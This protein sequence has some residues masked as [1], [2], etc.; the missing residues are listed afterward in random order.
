[1]KEC[2]GSAGIEDKNLQFNKKDSPIS[3]RFIDLPDRMEELRSSLKASHGNAAIIIH[4]FFFKKDDIYNF[5]NK[6][7]Y[8]DQEYEK[9]KCRLKNS[10]NKYTKLGL[11]IIVFEEKHEVSKLQQNFENIKINNGDIYLVPTFPSD[12]QPVG[13]GLSPLL[14]EFKKIGLTRTIIAG[15]YL[16]I[17]NSKNMYHEPIHDC[18]EHI[19]R[20]FKSYILAGCVGDALKK[21]LKVGIN[22]TPAFATFPYREIF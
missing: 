6:L 8:S 18:E 19:P 7:C 1:M 2:L 13:I 16:W 15:S 9:Y 22:A 11:P 21:C 14:R 4:P 3:I 17:R 20:N 12:P 10:I 5:P